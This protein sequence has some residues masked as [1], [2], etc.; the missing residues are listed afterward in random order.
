[1]AALRDCRR[2]PTIDA[3][4]ERPPRRPFREVTAREA[5]EASAGLA[6]AV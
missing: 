5:A 6:A 1:M 3:D 4:Q 2:N